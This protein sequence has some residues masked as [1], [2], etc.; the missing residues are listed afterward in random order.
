MTS[1]NKLYLVIAGY[2]RTESKNMRII[3]GI[4]S[5]I[6]EYRKFEEW[7]K[8]G[9]NRTVNEN[10]MRFHSTNTSAYGTELI[11]SG[12][13]EWS[14]KSTFPRNSC[15]WIGISSDFT[16]RHSSNWKNYCMIWCNGCKAIQGNIGINH[17]WQSALVKVDS[18]W[19]SGDIITIKLDLDKQ[20]ISWYRNKDAEPVAT[21]KKV[22]NAS[23]KVAV[24]GY[25]ADT[26]T[27]MTE[28]VNC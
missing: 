7:S 24:H 20:T 9:K 27:I 3:D 8:E 5:I 14:I 15:Q 12:K 4:I 19:I 26:Y 23:Y 13:Y 11:S 21:Y 6:F 18:Y 1:Y 25:D 16:E 10:S 22:P 2:W 28:I 17:N